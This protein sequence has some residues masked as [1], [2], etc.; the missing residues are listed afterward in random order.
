M[1]RLYPVHERSREHI[2]GLA[3]LHQQEDE[4]IHTHLPRLE[5]MMMMMVVIVGAHV[6]TTTAME[7][8]VREGQGSTSPQRFEQILKCAVCPCGRLWELGHD[9]QRADN[10]PIIAQYIVQCECKNEAP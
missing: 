6:G 10:E 8:E 2:F 4:Y 9:P 5:V 1:S 7:L 3:A